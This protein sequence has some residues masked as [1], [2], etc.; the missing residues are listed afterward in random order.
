[1]NTRPPMA[2]RVPRRLVL[3]LKLGEMPDHL[4]SLREVR[5]EGAAGRPLQPSF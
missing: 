3:T 2:L 1:M 4:P 5:R